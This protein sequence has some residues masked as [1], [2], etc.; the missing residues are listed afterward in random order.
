MQR[1]SRNRIDS[2]ERRVYQTT[3]GTRSH[4][5]RYAG[6][7]WSRFIVSLF[8]IMQRAGDLSICDGMVMWAMRLYAAE[9]T[10]VRVIGADRK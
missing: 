9:T 10:D 2:S 8:I 5:W 1:V 7:V 4:T 6:V 3:K